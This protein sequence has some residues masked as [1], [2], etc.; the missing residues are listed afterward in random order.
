[1]LGYTRWARSI[2]IESI[3]KNGYISVFPNKTKI[4]GDDLISLMKMSDTTISIS[5]FTIHTA[6]TSP[7]FVFF[8]FNSLSIR[9]QFD[10]FS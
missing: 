10:S 5:D 1:M 3:F 6:P 7:K 8:D 4:R 2:K 9:Y